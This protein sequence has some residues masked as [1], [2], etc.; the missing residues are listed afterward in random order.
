MVG[1]NLLMMVKGGKLNVWR[2]E[3]VGPWAGQ[4]YHLCEFFVYWQV[5]HVLLSNPTRLSV[6]SHHS[7]LNHCQKDEFV[8]IFAFD[9]TI[10]KLHPH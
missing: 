10:D 6:V 3:T 1:R 2:K 4:C 7:G 9:D 5:S 8:I